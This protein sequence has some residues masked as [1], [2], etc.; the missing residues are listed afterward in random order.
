MINILII[1][2]YWPPAG[3]PGVQRMLKFVKYL[4]ELGIKPHV[5]TVR[6]GDYPAID[7]TLADDIP[8]NLIVKKVKGWE[9]YG[10]FRFLTRRKKDEKIP[11]GILVQDNQSIFKK[12]FSW[13]R[14]NFFI[15]DGRLFLVIPFIRATRKMIQDYQIEGIITTGP[16]HSMHLPALWV[17]KRNS[18]NWT[19]D[20]RDPWTQ[21]YYYESQPRSMLAKRIDQW[22]ERSVLCRADDIITVSPQIARQL[23]SISGKTNVVTIYNGYDK[24]D[25]SSRLNSEVK[26]RF[27]IAYLG[28]FKANQNIDELWSVLSDLSSKNNE[29]ANALEIAIVGN[30]HL[31]VI[32][33][34][35]KRGL[36]KFLKLVKYVPHHQAIEIM[37][38]SSV[39]LFI[40]PNVSGNA[41][42]VTG[43]LFD[44]LAASRPLLSIGPPNGDAAKILYQVKAGEMIDP[45]DIVGLRN[46]INNLFH[47][48]K[49]NKLSSAVPE[50]TLIKQFERRQLTRTLSEVIMNRINNR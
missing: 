10:I 31:E 11:V 9:P 24:A 25:F 7:E 39:L 6:N 4:P 5:I 8:A 41:G 3:G 45:S 33:K 12:I 27:R 36:S 30:F 19:A 20:F 44:Y 13:I 48:W 21:I 18:I 40:I 1:T 15:P 50:R 37:R 23:S 29:L 34:L 35:N 38:N 17:S 32:D 14:L 42:I 26:G 46:R 47:L 43:K 16:P 49:I 2:Y 28:N 22:L